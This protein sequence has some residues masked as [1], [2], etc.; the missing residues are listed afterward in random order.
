MKIKMNYFSAY[1]LLIIVQILICNYF[2]FSAFVML[3]ILPV[4]VLCI[5]IRF[6]TPVVMLIAF[7]T[8]W[9]V[10]VFAEGVWGLDILALVPVAFVRRSVIQ[11]VFGEDL[12]ARKEDFSIR[13]NGFGKVSLAVI[14]VQA[15]FLLIYIAADGAGTRPFWFNLVRFA[16]SLV[17]GYAMSMLIIDTLAPESRK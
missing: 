15:L 9:V 16:A 2:H 4:M 17:A 10:D 12:F 5:P 6:S 13:R 11:A 14:I 1:V 7:A 8:G 3:S